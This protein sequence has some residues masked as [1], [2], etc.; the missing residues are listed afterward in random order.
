MLKK[1]A[2]G[3]GVLGLGAA[4]AFKFNKYRKEQELVKRTLE[5]DQKIAANPINRNENVDD[6]LKRVEIDSESMSAELKQKLTDQAA[7]QRTW[8][9]FLQENRRGLIL[10]SVLT[11]GVATGAIL[12]S[13][14]PQVN[15]LTELA[16]E[17]TSYVSSAATTATGW[18][19]SVVAP[20][21]TIWSRLTGTSGGQLL[22]TAPLPGVSLES[23]SGP[24]PTPIGQS[25][26]P[27]AEAIRQAAAASQLSFD[28][29]S[30]QKK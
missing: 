11:V 14:A 27:P 4:A 15:K 20:V 3:A 18:I 30:K 16:L 12:Y 2:M 13:D 19:S 23:V 10:A 17:S 25:A 24:M 22:L 29:K 9:E 6:Y 21:T 8:S 5:L 28:L 7:Q 1:A 26:V